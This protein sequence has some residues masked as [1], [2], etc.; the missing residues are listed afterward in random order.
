[1][2]RGSQ[3]DVISIL[4]QAIAE[5]VGADRFELWFDSATDFSINEKSLQVRV[6]NRF[7]QE[8]IRRSFQDCIQQAVLETTGHALDIRFE[9][10]SDE[11]RSSDPVKLPTTAKT[12][13]KISDSRS[14]T[15]S[16]SRPSGSSSRMSPK[17]WSSLEDFVVGA[18]N[19]LAHASIQRACLPKSPWNLLLVYGSSGLGKTHLLQAA[20]RSLMEEGR[21]LRVVYLKAEQFTHEFV[22]ALRG[23]SMPSFRKRYRG[24]DVLA[25]D[26]I[27]FLIG[28]NATQEE[29]LN[30]IDELSARGC[31]VFLAGDRSIQ[32]MPF[33][34]EALLTRLMA[35]ISC[36]IDNPDLDTR[37]AILK[38]K[39]AQ[40]KMVL[41]E[42]VLR[43]VAERFHESVRQLE[44]VIHRLRA[45]YELLDASLDIDRVRQIL[46]DLVRLEK[47]P[48]RLP[49]VEQA[50]CEVFGLSPKVL[51]SNMRQRSV[52][53]PR[54]MAMY[55]ARKHT[56]AAYREIG[57][58]FGGRNHSTVISAEKKVSGWVE[59]SGQSKVDRSLLTIQDALV[60]VEHQLRVG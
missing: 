25:V 4:R 54:M 59:Q 27:Q 22:S 41:S 52:S 30:T 10:Q 8:R 38:S 15:K 14:S 20:C 21:P 13:H 35:G 49:Q 34:N 2:R 18:T 47:R 3:Q 45:H 39:A 17:Y 16:N 57:E 1:M 51:R 23:G 55:L 56:Q 58:Y 6:P 46:T 40:A 32:S 11:E 29:F 33:A 12:P 7:Y 28:K 37:L 31:R 48:V 53:Q 5:R 60:A 50:V 26:D 44:G 24:V 43:Y 36:P 19:H 42:E 9:V